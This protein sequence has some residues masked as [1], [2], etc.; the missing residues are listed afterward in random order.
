[1]REQWSSRIG[2]ILATAGFSIGLGNIWRFPYLA[3]ENGGGAFL[4]VYVAFAVMIGIPLMTAEVGLGRKTQL[5]PIAGMARLTGSKTSPWNLVGWFGI[6]A[7][8]LITAYYI[9]IIAW[10]TAYFVML[11]R[12]GGELGQTPEETR[13]AFDAF[14]AT[15]GPVF[16]YAFLVTLLVAYVVSRGVTKGIERYARFLMP[17]LV[18]LLVA[19]AIRALTLPG[20]AAG[21]VWYLTPNFSA[22]T[23]TSVLAALGQAFFSI[24]IGMAGGFVMGSYLNRHDTDVPGNTALVVAF[25]TGVAVV[26]GLVLFPALFAFGMDPDQGAGL[27]FITMT[28]LFQQMPGGMVFGAAFFFLMLVAGFTSQVAVFES[29][30]ATVVDSL[31]MTRKRAVVLCAAG[32]FLLCVPVI[33]SQ[34]PWSHIHIFGMS[35]F[36]FANTVSSDY[37]LGAGGLLLSLYVVSKWGWS[38]FREET[39]QGAGRVKVTAAWGP[40]IRF[41]IPVSVALVLLGSF[42]VGAGNP[43]LFLGCAAAVILVYAFFLRRFPA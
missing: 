2:F 12:G 34:G 13:A 43:A 15:P 8:T 42:G 20:A 30:V 41:V 7:A 33:L 21:V 11:V 19:L 3:G 5:T 22:L 40:L 6:T 37:L 26:A 32:G 1:M 9:M 17:L 39:N 24:G 23:G 16:G 27:L 36:D 14:I 35:F 31:G 25:D 38:R 10:V 4:L 28:S 18:V 29:L